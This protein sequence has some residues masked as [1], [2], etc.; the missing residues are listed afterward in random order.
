MKYFVFLCVFQTPNTEAEW[1]AVQSKFQQKW[2]FPQCLGALDGKHVRIKCPK[3]GGSGFYNYQGFNSIVL[4]AIVDASYKFLYHEVGA[5]GRTGDAI[6]WNDSPF[7]RDLE[8]GLWNTPPPMTTPRTN[9]AVPSLIIADAAFALSP[10]L[11]KPFPD[12]G[13]DNSKVVFNYRLSRARRV[14]ENAFGILASRF[15]MYQRTMEQQPPQLKKFVLASLALHNF[16]RH[17]KDQQ[18]CGA[19]Y[20]DWEQGNDH[21]LVEGGWREVPGAQLQG[22]RAAPQNQYAAGGD[23][24][25]ALKAYFMSEG[26]VPWQNASA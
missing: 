12:R 4:F 15:G 22:L 16:L 10:Q 26:A 3:R 2:N 11:M 1:I 9:F 5:E 25:H 19:G 24:R 13:I 6:I 8:N 17:R 7:K 14:V 23:I 20:A 18:Y 21:H